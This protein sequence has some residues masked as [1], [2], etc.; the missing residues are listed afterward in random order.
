MSMTTVRAVPAA[1][2]ATAA[3]V[4]QSMCTDVSSPGQAAMSAGMGGGTSLTL[5]ALTT[6]RRDAA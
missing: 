3:K 5:S 6:E 1:T 4:A 2:T